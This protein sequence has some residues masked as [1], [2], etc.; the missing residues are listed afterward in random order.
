M[1]FFPYPFLSG[2]LS[3]ML[4]LTMDPKPKRIVDKQYLAEVKKL[5]CAACGGGPSDPE[6]VRTVAA[7]GNDNYEGV[8]PLCRPCHTL[9]HSM[10]YYAFCLKYPKVKIALYDRGWFIDMHTGKL[11]RR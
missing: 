11:S 3:P 2:I 1:T 9:R 6:H 7:G 10:G 4:I 5:P 8:I